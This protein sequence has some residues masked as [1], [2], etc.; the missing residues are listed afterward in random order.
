MGSNKMLAEWRGKPLVRSVVDAAL[1]SSAHP[2]IVVTGHESAKVEMALRGL[3]V[4]IVHNPDY[5]KGLSTSLKAGIRAVPAD[6]DGALVLLGDMPEIAPALI[7]RM[8][9]AF[10][11]PDGRSIC[12][13][14]HDHMRGNPVLWAKAF[15][16]EIEMLSGDAG[17]KSLLAAHEDAVCEIEA[18]QSVLRDIDTPEALEAL[19][20]GVIEPAK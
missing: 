8:I 7:D 16:S 17:A 10:S 18:G 2:V 20:A 15:F 14:M 6:C 12:V 9:A 19:R 13:A 11:P 4:Q 5:A 1:K 3:D